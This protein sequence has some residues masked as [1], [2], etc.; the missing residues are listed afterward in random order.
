MTEIVQVDAVAVS[1]TRH[2]RTNLT[3]QIFFRRM[4]QWRAS[5]Q[6]VVWLMAVNCVA[7]YLR[8]DAI[9]GALVV[10]DAHNAIGEV[11]LDIG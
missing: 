8:V 2:G 9:D 1:Q 11:R 3:R 5:V 6:N 7:D 4:N 10:P